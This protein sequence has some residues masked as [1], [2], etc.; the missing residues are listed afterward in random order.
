VVAGVNVLDWYRLFTWFGLAGIAAAVVLAA[1][2][3]AGPV[4][5]R[6]RRTGA[7]GRGAAS[8]RAAIPGQG[9]PMAAVITSVA[10][11]GSLYLSEGGHL[12]P[13]RLCWFQRCAMY[14]LAV[15]LVIAS[16]RRDRAVRPYALSLSVIGALISTW[17]VAL[18]W[19]PSL[20]GIGG[21]CAFDAPCSARL[22]PLRYGFMSIP[23]MALIAFVLAFLLVIMDRPS[24]TRSEEIA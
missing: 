19:R 1:A 17:H 18:E 22:L 5:G 21:S 10:M 12:T 14:P 2:L 20:E 4:A 13:C 6:F 11:A 3:F 16:V 7:L 15:L 8:L 24:P 9:I 23:T